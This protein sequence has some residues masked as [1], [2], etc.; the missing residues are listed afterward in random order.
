MK[1]SLHHNP[2]LGPLLRSQRLWQ[3]SG[4]QKGYHDSAYPNHIPTAYPLLDNALASKGWLTGVNEILCDTPGIGEVQLV[5][6][7]KVSQPLT[8]WINPPFTPFGLGLHALPMDATQTLII[9]PQHADQF[10]WSVRTCLRSG[11]VGRILAWPPN[12]QPRLAAIM[13]Q[14]QVMASETRCPMFVFRPLIA[15]NQPSPASLRMALTATEHAL[16]ATIIKCKGQA[17]HSPVLLSM[18]HQQIITNT[19]TNK[20][21]TTDDTATQIDSPRPP[22]SDHAS[23]PYPLM[24]Q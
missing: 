22:V 16:C 5:L 2:L 13:R 1:S 10:M 24:V 14:W 23:S 19:M 12:K 17:H 20:G 7:A 4:P 8:A 21:Q 15:A 11:Q 6:R 18:P 3:G 9:H